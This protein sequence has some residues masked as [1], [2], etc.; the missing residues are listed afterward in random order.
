MPLSISSSPPSCIFALS[1]PYALPIS[2]PPAPPSRAGRFPFVTAGAGSYTEGGRGFSSLRVREGFRH[3]T[4]TPVAR[5]VPGA[6]SRDRKSARPNSSHSSSSYADLPSRCLSRSARRRLPASSLFPY[7]TLFR[8]RALPRRPPAPADF[9][10]SRPAREVTLKGEEDFPP[11][12]CERASAM[13]R[14]LQW[15]GLFLALA[16]EIGRAHVRTPVT[17]PVRTPICRVDAS[18]DQLVAAFLHLRSFPT[19]RSSDLGPSRAALPR[20]PISV[21]HGRRGK[22]H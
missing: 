22:L 20:R 12:G 1:L 19:L 13:R 9:R 10:L 21:C 6:G 2:G 7:P 18:L 5:A 8:S 14:T 15:A 17:R 11:F 4:N 3:S 16:A